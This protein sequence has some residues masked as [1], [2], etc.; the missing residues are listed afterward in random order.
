MMYALPMPF[1]LTDNKPMASINPQ[2]YPKPVD[3]DD[4]HI[5]NNEH[6]SNPQRSSVSSPS[7]GEV[8]NENASAA[9]T[10]ESNCSKKD[11]DKRDAKPPPTAPKPVANKESAPNKRLYENIDLMANLPKISDN[12]D[13]QKPHVKSEEKDQEAVNGVYEEE[14]DI[15]NTEDIYGCYRSMGSSSIL[16]DLQKSLLASL[17]SG[18]L[19]MEFAV[20]NFLIC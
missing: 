12:D 4:I 7:S 20:K 1:M 2:T 11:K 13:N 16:D 10:K 15:Y 6:L 19:G 5:Y 17:A 8:G 18:K 9:K 3:T 14:E